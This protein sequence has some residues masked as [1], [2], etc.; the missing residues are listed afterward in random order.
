VGETWSGAVALQLAALLESAGHTVELFLLE[1]APAVAHQL[2]KALTDNH[3]LDIT[4]IANLLSLENKVIKSKQLNGIY[5]GMPTI[6]AL[7]IEANPI[8]LYSNCKLSSPVFRGIVGSVMGGKA[9]T[10]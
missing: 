10:T 5:Q 3:P 1:G 7:N 6:Q 2:A 4:L 8:I 9:G